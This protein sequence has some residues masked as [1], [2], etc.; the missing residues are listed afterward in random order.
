MSLF[1]RIKTAIPV[2]D[3]GNMA[4]MLA[5]IAITIAIGA[6]ILTEVAGSDTFTTSTDSNLSVVSALDAVA[7]F[8]DWLG[9]IAIV[10]VAVVVLSLIKYL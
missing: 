6:L 5:I 3:L 10:I 9:I 1:K 4:T 8:G 7:T 2:G